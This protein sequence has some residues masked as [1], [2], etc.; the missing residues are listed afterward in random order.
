MKALENLWVTVSVIF[1]IKICCAFGRYSEVFPANYNKYEPPVYQGN[2]AHLYI[3]LEILD[4]DR[5]DESRMEFSIQTYIIEF[6]RD[7]RLNLSSYTFVGGQAFPQTLVPDLWNPDL[8]FDNAKSGVLFSLSVPN[9]NMVVAN[10]GLTLIRSSRYNLVIGCQ[11]N[12]LYYPMDTQLCFF[13]LALFSNSDK[14][15]LHWSDEDGNPN[16]RPKAIT[17]ANEIQALKYKIEQPKTHKTK[18]QWSSVLGSGCEV[19][20]LASTS[21]P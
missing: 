2:P 18:E 7:W 14:V 21:Q 5:I 17:F 13:K 10:D 12:F 1:T 11:M 8:V 15:T 16:R 20:P 4:I 19:V 6:W 3:N 9:T